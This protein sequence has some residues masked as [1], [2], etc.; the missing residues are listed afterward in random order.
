M[1]EDFLMMQR[2][3]DS[4]SNLRESFSIPEKCNLSQR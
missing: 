1:S 4:L 3:G 2:R